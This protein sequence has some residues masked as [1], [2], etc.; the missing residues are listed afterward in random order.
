MA[1]YIA[2]Q[3]AHIINDDEKTMIRKLAL[4]ATFASALFAAAPASAQPSQPLTVDE[5]FLLQEIS[6]HNSAIRTMAGRFEQIDSQGGRVEGTFFLNRPN[7]IRFRYGP[8]SREE[9][10]SQGQG[11]YVIDRA[12][13]TQYAYPQEQVPLRQFLGDQV[14][15][16]NSDLSDVVVSDSY[17]SVMISDDSPIGVVQVSLIFERS[18]NDLVQW[19]LIEPSGVETT[20]SIVEAEKN[21]EIPSSYFYIDPTYRSV[22]A[23]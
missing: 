15:L 1:G 19:S 21:V 11:F 13:R 17:V 23:N 5:E 3:G 4:L 6:R 22:S 12:E 10:I 8:P 18:T 16:I 14:D 9:I 20:F 7:Q 2:N